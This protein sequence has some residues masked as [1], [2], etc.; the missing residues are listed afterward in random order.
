ML[1]DDDTY[2]E[3]IAHLTQGGPIVCDTETTGLEWRKED[4][5]CGIGLLASGKSFYFPF[6]HAEGPNLPERL[7][8]DVCERVLRPGRLHIGYHYGF[9]INMLHKE[10]MCA[11]EKIEDS[12]LNAHVLNEN[13]PSFK[14]ENVCTK[15]INPDASKE[16]DALIDLLVERFGGSRKRAKANLHK[17]P[18]SEVAGY[19]EQDLWS[20]LELRDWQLPHLAAWGLTEVAV[21]VCEYQLVV[22]ESERLGM[23]LDVS[24]VHE[25]M[26]EAEIKAQ[27]L[28][29]AIAEKAGYKANPRS[30]KQMQALLNVASTARDVLDMLVAG[31]N[32]T[33]ELL[34]DYRVWSKAVGTY[35]KPFLECMTPGGV[36]HPNINVMGTISGR[37]TCS[38]PNMLAIPR[39]VKKYPIKKVFVARPGYMFV[40]VD[41]SQ[42]EMRVAAHYANEV[43]MKKLFSNRGVDLHGAVAAERGMPR[44]IAKR[45]N[46]SVIY[47]IGARKFSKTYKVPYQ[48]AKVYLNDYHEMFPGFRRLY[49]KAD[50]IAQTRGYI[51]HFSGRI[52]R[53]NDPKRAPSHKASSNLVQGSVA[54]MIRLTIIRLRKEFPWARQLLSVY[55]SVLFEVPDTTTD[56]EIN[57]I[58]KLMEDQPWCSVPMKVDIKKGFCWGE[59][60]EIEWQ[61]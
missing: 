55:D 31:G 37:P 59:M 1:V 34:M 44:D 50:T 17:L 36:I 35:Y 39:D 9:D 46:F 27:E 28:E 13:E 12:M 22:A 42:A 51:R 56:E 33:A 57:Q 60:E 61:E 3:A 48:K 23:Q 25:Y 40:E 43:K 2:E 7:I 8:G 30:S 20:T 4:K 32:E 54:E 19:A 15:Y 10:G 14:M 47:G 53:F 38:N 45:L 18:A 11:P 5:V 49:N 52:R 26:K 21:G 29:D 16:E 58:R 41:V 6:R 24:R